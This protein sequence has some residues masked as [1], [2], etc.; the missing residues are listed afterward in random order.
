MDHKP[1]TDPC[2]QDQISHSD[3]PAPPAHLFCPFPSTT[4]CTSLILYNIRTSFHLF[5]VF[6]E[7][8]TTF[9]IK[10]SPSLQHIFSVYSSVETLFCISIGLEFEIPKIPVIIG[11]ALIPTPV[12]WRLATSIKARKIKYWAAVILCSGCMEPSERTNA[13]EHHPAAE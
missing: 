5:C 3:D 10:Y 4:P 13:T 8:H 11:A 12:S 1:T 7:A 9:C 2:E 6:E